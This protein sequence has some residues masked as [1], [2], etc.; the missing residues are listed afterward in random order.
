MFDWALNAYEVK[1][2]YNLLSFRRLN[3]VKWING[4]QL[5]LLQ[6]KAKASNSKRSG[7]FLVNTNL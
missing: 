6:M 4:P 5:Y 1:I 7:R 2:V 3:F